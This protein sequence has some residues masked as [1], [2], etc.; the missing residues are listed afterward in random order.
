MWRILLAAFPVCPVFFAVVRRKAF[1]HAG[2]AARV[3]RAGGSPPGFRHVW[4][5]KKASSLIQFQKLP[6]GFPQFNH[7]SSGFAPYAAA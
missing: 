1:Y 6:I 5:G 7:F 4:C 3:N 2:F